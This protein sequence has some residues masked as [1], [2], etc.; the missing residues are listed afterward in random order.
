MLPWLPA[1]LRIKANGV[2]WPQN[3]LQSGSRFLLELSSS[4]PP[5]MLLCSSTL[6]SALVFEACLRL[7]PLHLQFPLSR[8]PFP[9]YPHFIE[10]YTNS[11]FSMKPFFPGSPLL[12]S[13]VT[14][15]IPSSQI[16]TFTHSTAFF[17][18]G[19][20]G[21]S[22]ALPLDVSGG[23]IFIPSVHLIFFRTALSI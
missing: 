5:P 1:L 4:C 17:C 20:D 7:R 14:P 15:S 13:A 9:I 6:A 16:Y 8:L 23:R 22:R 2:K 12:N 10:P 21:L 3:P 11:I 18:W 19:R